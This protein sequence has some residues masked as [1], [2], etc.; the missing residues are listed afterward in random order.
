MGSRIVLVRQLGAGSTGTVFLATSTQPGST[1]VAVKLLHPQLSANL[2]VVRSFLEEHRILVE[3]QHPNL[4]SVID[5]VV[6]DGAL[7]IVMELI[8]GGDLRQILSVPGGLRPRQAFTIA[9]QIAGALA[10]VHQA[11]VVHRDVKPENVLLEEVPGGDPRVRLTDFGIA[12]LAH[13]GDAESG[14][15]WL[16]T[17]RYLA[18]ELPRGEAP[19]PAS[20]MYALGCL[21]YEMLTGRTPFESEYPA[22]LLWRHANEEVPPI[23][24]LPSNAERLLSSLLEKEPTRRPSAA[25]AA[26]R[27]SHLARRHGRLPRLVADAAPPP[28][29]RVRGGFVVGSGVVQP[30]GKTLLRGDLATM[31]RSPA[32]SAVPLLERSKRSRR[33]VWI[34]AGVGVALLV[35]GLAVLLHRAT[36]PPPTLRLRDVVTTYPA[37]L[38][39]RRQWTLVGKTSQKLRVTTIVTARSPLPGGWLE[40]LPPSLARAFPSASSSPDAALLHGGLSFA[41]A[42]LAGAK[43]KSPARFRLAYDIPLPGG[44]RGAAALRAF[45]DE[46]G[47][48]EHDR[49]VV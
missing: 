43:P 27:L 29:V 6:E 3:L 13:A 26:K 20:D 38:V 23:I 8:P 35:A 15:P 2:A 37:G 34:G 39:E 47:R 48:A 46:Q 14:S 42:H 24:G 18:P 21:L 16:G 22:A 28:D 10:Y 49:L 45:A 41:D 11:G 40:V 19:G 9:A 25:E 36:R 4:A 32:P 17:P 5:L 33:P 31:N 44:R 12:S 1:Q 7:A 30:A